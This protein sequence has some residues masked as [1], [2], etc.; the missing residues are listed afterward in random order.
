MAPNR[1]EAREPFARTFGDWDTTAVRSARL[2][3]DGGSLR[4][5]SDL[6]DELRAD[7]RCG[8]VLQQLSLALLGLPLTFEASGDGR[9]RNRVVRAVESDDDWWDMTS[10]AELADLFE[11]GI[12]EGVGLAEL[13]WPSTA[14][15]SGRVVPRLKVWHPRWL[16]WDW[17]KRSWWLWTDDSAEIEIT[18]GDGKWLLFTP[19]GRNRPWARGLWRRLAM[20]WLLKTFALTDW[21]RHSELHGLPLRVGSSPEGSTPEQRDL[22]ADD[23]DNLG[24]DTSIVLPPG[25]ELDFQEAVARTWEMFPKQ[26]ESA[27]QA[28]AIAVLGQNLTTE[29]QGGSFAA[30]NVHRVVKGELLRFYAE[31]FATCL[32]DHLLEP[33]AEIN[34]GTRALAPWPQW[35]I[36]DPPSEAAPS[37]TPTPVPNVTQPAKDG[38]SEDSNDDDTPSA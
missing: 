13:V 12:I 25:Y 8:G 14:T 27:D 2:I 18:P 32:H 21:A 16:R 31:A 17:Q 34:F 29:V 33:W 6:V 1:K 3:A 4:A 9:R 7:D 30:A 24:R 5:L 26:I 28:I 15:A 10:E 11:W 22:F 35:Q 19:F 23:L 36:P 38:V 20:K 37:A